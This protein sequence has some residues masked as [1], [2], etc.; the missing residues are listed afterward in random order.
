MSSSGPKYYYKQPASASRTQL[1]PSSAA[2]ENFTSLSR[3]NSL[4]SSTASHT[5]SHTSNDFTSTYYAGSTPSFRRQPSR[6]AVRNL[7]PHNDIV[8]AESHRDI[9]VQ[10]D[11]PYAVGMS[12][13][14][15]HVTEVRSISDKVLRR[16]S[17]IY[18]TSLPCPHLPS[19]TVLAL[20]RPQVLGLQS[21]PHRCRAR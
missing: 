11:S 3:H 8:C 13:H 9:H 17:H 10:N 12:A 16:A 14:S 19:F 1:L 2:A 7:Y 4:E 20:P 6:P 5:T 21:L 15:R 18:F